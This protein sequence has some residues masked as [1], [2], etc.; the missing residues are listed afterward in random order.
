MKIKKISL[1]EIKNALNKDEMKKVVGGCSNPCNVMC[2]V[3][4]PG[5]CN[6]IG[7]GPTCHNEGQAAGGAWGVCS[8]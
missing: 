3:S 7:C 5:Y 1:S 4:S 2:L 8:L 6:E